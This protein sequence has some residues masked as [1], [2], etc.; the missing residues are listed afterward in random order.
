MPGNP[1][2][3]PE[4][5]WHCRNDGTLLGVRRGDTVEV[6]YKSAAYVVRGEVT[7]RCRRCG[8]TNHLDT[9]NTRHQ[10]ATA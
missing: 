7:T 1:I 5:E 2:P 3:S 6:R 4:R 9:R 10:A 8:T